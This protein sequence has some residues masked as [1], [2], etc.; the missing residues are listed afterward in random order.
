[1]SQGGA[2]PASLPVGSR[3][4]LPAEA[5]ELRAIEAALTARFAAWGYR[6]V[7]T[8][9]LEFASV[10][11]RA[12]EGGLRHA[13]RLFDETGRVLVLRPDLTIPVAR[14]VSG[15]LADHPGPVR[16]FYLG[17]AFQSP[18][19]GR[20]WPAEL[21]QAG[22]ELVGAAGPAADAEVL[23][24]L[25]ESLAATGVTGVRVAVGDVWLTQAVLDGAGIGVATRERMRAA[26]ARRDLVSWREEARA[27]GA[28]AIVEELPRLRGGRDILA[29]IAEESDGARAECERLTTML[30]LLDRHGVGSAVEIDLGVLRDRPYYTGIVAEAYAPGVGSPIAA[31]GR[32]DGLA[33]RFG[34]A[35]AAVGVA[36]SL[37]ALHRAVAAG[38]GGKG[39]AP[40][41]LGV[42]LAGGMDDD[43]AGAY[44]TRA[45]GHTVV[46]LEA[47]GDGAEALAAADGWRFVA[48]RKGRGYEVVDIESGQRIA[49]ATLA[50]GLPS[51]A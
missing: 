4:V 11:D 7:V 45:A 22:I 8:P 3:D 24:L 9:A 34:H 28:P 39:F 44:A 43:I 10:M 16:V 21:R 33:E 40:F 1:M 25:V 30:D 13:F 36:V 50:E 27:A 2:E 12:A 49:C 35:R 17:T 38:E 51:P 37:D 32:Y 26:I 18:P 41:P 31:G 6:E 46:A 15:R 29:R 20:A 42:V 14:L 47:S 23:A 48:H 19:A 5:T